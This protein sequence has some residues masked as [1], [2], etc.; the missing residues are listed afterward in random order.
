MP[1]LVPRREV[2][3]WLTLIFIQCVLLATVARTCQADD[4]LAA[5]AH[6]DKVVVSKKDHT[7]ELFDHGKLLKKYKVALGGELAGRK[8]RQ[9]DHKTPEGL[10]VL[11][12]RNEHSQFYKSPHVSYPNAEDRARA[13]KAG[14]NP[15]G[16]IMVHG[17]PNG[18]GWIGNGHRVRDWTDGC[19]AVTNEE[20]D[21]IWR[22]VA[23]G[24]P[25]EIRP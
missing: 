21:E 24:T 14:V 23:D 8:E 5:D 20:M 25:I 1:T 22:M 12:R 15:G 9:G 17:L 4:R 19:I 10:Y 7:L 11:D 18:F 3:G 2:S 13:Q 6:A 16:D